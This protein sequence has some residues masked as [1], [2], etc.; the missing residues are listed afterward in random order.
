[1]WTLRI[2]LFFS[3]EIRNLNATNLYK[4]K[5]YNDG[6]KKAFGS[7]PRFVSYNVWKF[8]KRTLIILVF[9]DK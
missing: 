6:I 9:I 7:I 1:M 2:L 3:L 8:T 5:F 4:Y